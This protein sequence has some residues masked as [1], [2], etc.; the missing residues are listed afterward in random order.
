M[1]HWHNVRSMLRQRRRQWIN[2][3]TTFGQCLVIK[4]RHHEHRKMSSFWAP[5][6]FQ[7]KYQLQFPVSNEREIPSLCY[8]NVKYPNDITAWLLSIFCSLFEPF[9]RVIWRIADALVHLTH[10]LYIPRTEIKCK[11]SWCWYKHCFLIMRL[12]GLAGAFVSAWVMRNSV[13]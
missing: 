13:C 10:K 9:H 11:I 6:F 5:P 12:I 7:L 2:I 1:R 3:D 4:Q 8:G